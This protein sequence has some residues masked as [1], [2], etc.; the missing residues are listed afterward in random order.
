MNILVAGGAG[1]IGSHL[2][3]SLLAE[4]NSVVCAD[5]LIMGDENIQHLYGRDNFK[6]Y[7]VELA[8][9]NKVDQIFIENKID[10]VYHLAANSD[11]QKGGKEPSIDFNDTLLTTRAL[12]EGMRKANIKKMFFASTSAIYGEML[13]VELTETTGGLMPVSYYGGAKLASEALISSYVSMCDMSVVIFRFPNVIGPRLTHGAVFDFIRKLR[14]NPAELEILGNGTQCKPY[15]YVLDLVEAIIKLTREFNQGEIVYN[16]SVIGE[17][18]TVTHIA[19]IVV[20]ELSL[21]NV[22]F[23]YTGGDRGW[24]GDVPRFSYDISKVLATGWKPK[25]TSDEAVRQ[26]VKDAIAAGM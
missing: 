20:E 6:F 7:N 5:K 14:N 24:K 19:E 16:I 12:L 13:D 15:I 4:G 3:D 26:T 1:F 2:I 22:N 11:I 18:T 23:N 9:Q 10:V 17:G 25:H 8:D 21:Q